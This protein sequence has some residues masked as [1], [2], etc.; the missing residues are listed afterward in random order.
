M[1]QRAKY[2]FDMDDVPFST[3]DAARGYAEINHIQ[4]TNWTYETLLAHLEGAGK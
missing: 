2:E 4:G 1:M 3:E